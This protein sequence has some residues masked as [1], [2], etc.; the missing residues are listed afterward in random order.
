MGKNNR[1]RR[2]AKAKQRRSGHRFPHWARRDSDAFGLTDRELAAGLFDLA[3]GCVLSGDDDTAAVAIGRLGQLPVGIVDAEIERMLRST[4]VVLW[5]NG[6]QPHEVVRQVRRDRS[7][8]AGRLATVVVVADHASR[9]ADT[10]D[11]GWAA[12]VAALGASVPPRGTSPAAG[13]FAGWR[14]Q[15]SLDRG[16]GLTVAVAVLSSLSGVGPIAELV[17]PPGRGRHR[18]SGSAAAVR[19]DDPVL[20]R[21][22]AL[23]AQAESTT[24]PAEAEAFTAK[25]HE[26]MTRYAI[27]QALLA[28]GN[29]DEQPTSRRIAL[30]DPYVDAKS[31]LLQVVA[32]HNRCRAVFD[33][34][35]AL[36]TVIGFG[37][38]LD[39]A[40]L[41]FTSLLVQAQV[42]L[43]GE[44]RNA[45]AGARTR[46]RSF[47][48]SFLVAYAARIGERLGEINRAVLNTV[49]AETQRSALP[50]LAARRSEVD[51]TIDR[52]FGH[53]LE[54]TPV[55]TTWDGFG[56]MRGK[57]AGNQAQ[58]SFANLTEATAS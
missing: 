21:V 5:D 42:A 57:I 30:D 34:R 11:P 35:Y 2:A 38:D 33:G 3:A 13:W 1:A 50:V 32:E 16:A 29:P 43:T 58:L 15:E 10:L 40:E 45:P 12:Q 49:E 53:T 54:H 24:F 17:P 51:D 55:K 8:A 14:E 37:P 4:L 39:A 7:T 20:A 46:G 22:R 9:H 52:L 25:A 47:R 56:A 26:L 23:L 31:Y 18:A 28:V 27:D 44:A 48:S 36:S 19:A 6:W 41:L